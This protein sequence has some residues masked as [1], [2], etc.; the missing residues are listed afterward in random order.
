M[1]I[2]LVKKVMSLCSGSFFLLDFKEM[3]NSNKS[4]ERVFIE[5][6]SY[7]NIND[8]KQ[9]CEDTVKSNLKYFV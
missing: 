5:F 3:I 4:N 8:L 6:L 1:A 2:P 9:K 7:N